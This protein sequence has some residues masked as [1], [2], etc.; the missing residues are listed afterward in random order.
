MAND[1]GRVVY[2][3]RSV[4]TTIVRRSECDGGSHDWRVFCAAQFLVVNER[5][6]FGYGPDGPARRVGLGH[7]V[8][9]SHVVVLRC[10]DGGSTLPVVL[11]GS[12]AFRSSLVEKA[13]GWSAV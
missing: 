2:V 6:V 4:V 5:D 8:R 3:P 9:L 1:R 7:A 10:Y 11:T 13:T 12:G